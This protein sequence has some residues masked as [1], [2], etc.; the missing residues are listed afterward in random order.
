MEVIRGMDEE[1]FNYI[2]KVDPRMWS[3]H[4]FRESSYS[5]ILLNN[6]AECFNSWILEA[7]EK[8]ILTCMEM[9]RRQIMNRFNLKRDGAATSTNSICPKIVRKLD[10]NKSNSRNYIA[11]CS[12]KLQ[13][14]VDHCY[15]PRRIVDLGKRTCTC[16]RWQLSG[17]PC[18]H[19]CCAIYRNRESLRSYLSS[20]YLMETL[21]KSYAPD[22]HPMPGPKEW[23]VDL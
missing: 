11:R 9:I 16:G 19:A 10:R 13:Y 6:T 21:R 4:A 15:D 8:P 7:R 2:D 14:E 12:N 23:P 20:W 1:A 18:P 5:D 22:I 17:I 3:R